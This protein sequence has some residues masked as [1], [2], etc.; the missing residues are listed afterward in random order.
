ML[1][2]RWFELMLPFF[3]IAE[4][5]CYLLILSLSESLKLTFCSCLLQQ[6][7]VAE[8]ASV[9]SSKWIYFK[10]FRKIFEV[11]KKIFFPENFLSS[12]KLKLFVQRILIWKNP[13]DCAKFCNVPRTIS[14]MMSIWKRF[15]EII[16]LSKLF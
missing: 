8:C 15:C 16:E 9:N 4:P 10:F 6:W 13:T 5:W 12:K 11:E 14:W 3:L 7:F 1:T 2:Q